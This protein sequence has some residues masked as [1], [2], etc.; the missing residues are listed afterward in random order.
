VTITI[1]PTLPLHYR[2]ALVAARPFLS[3]AVAL[4]TYRELYA[5]ALKAPGEAFPARALRA[6]DITVDV[7][8]TDL[9]SVPMSGPLVVA[10]NHPHGMLDGLLLADVVQRKRLD[11]RILTNHV[12]AQLPELEDL[13]FFVD[14][15]NRRDAASRSR[16]GL[17]AAMRWLMDGHA[18]IVFPSGGVAAEDQP[19]VTTPVDGAWHDTFSRL[20]GRVNAPVVPAF[21]EGRN[22]AWFYRAGCLHPLL[23]TLL[24]PRELLRKRGSIV[25][26]RLAPPVFLPRDVASHS[27]RAA[28]ALVRRTVE[29]LASRT[30]TLEAE[31]AALGAE[32]R[33]VANG[34]FEVFCARAD[35]IPTVLGEI[36]RLRE[37]T[38]R[39][40]GEGTGRAIDLDRFDGH[41]LHLFV[42][43]RERR[44]VIGA[45]RLGLTD[46]IAASKGISGLYTSTLFRYDTTLLNR[47]PPAIELGRSFVREEYQRSSNALLLLWKGIAAFVSR[48]KRYRVLFGPVSISSR[49]GDMSQHLLRAFLTH[50]FYQR[51]LGALVD[52][53]HP[54][55]SGPLPA[56]I[57]PKVISSVQGVDTLLSC[58]ESDGKGIPV[59]LR[60]Y[61]R[62]NA[63]LLGFNVD[64]AFGNALDALMMVDLADVD[65]AILT[66]YFGKVEARALLAVY[67]SHR[68]A[69]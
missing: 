21:I 17:R 38:F 53:R 63:K 59:L 55:A 36:G 1:P 12:L 60:Q 27:G 51:E 18:L 11:V 2:A 14:P 23:R 43:H 46:E 31:V 24:L 39:A 47:L 19:G 41:Y 62:L 13:C 61:L 29:R 16:A 35:Q 3:W 26:V 6:L 7:A 37:V 32:E 4:E 40:V 48:S 68:Q 22:S 66:R 42:W 67:D 56:G 33:L 52:A 34:P 50:N 49:Y 58:L 10:A 8:R 25:R 57:D 5:Q 30:H 54:P 9:L 15:F 44:E 65:R 45:Y 28:T 20:A 64:P 69:A